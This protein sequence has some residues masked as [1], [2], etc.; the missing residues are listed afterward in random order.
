MNIRSSFFILNFSFFILACCCHAADVEISVVPSNK[1]YRY[2]IDEPI[3]V[4]LSIRNRTGKTIDTE[5]DGRFTCEVKRMGSPL[6]LTPY[7]DATLPELSIK[8]G[9]TEVVEID[10]TDLY[11]LRDEGD[12]FIRFSAANAIA[13][14]RSDGTMVN[15]NAGIPVKHVSQL[16]DD[17]TRREFHLVYLE[18]DQTEILFLRIIDPAG[19][20][21]WDT[22][23]LNRIWRIDEPKMGI[24]DSGLVTIMHRASQDLYII[25]ELL[26]ER[27][28][29]RM[30]SMTPLLTPEAQARVNMQPFQNMLLDPPKPKPKPW[31]KLW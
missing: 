27:N 23:W 19:E 18:R 9:E 3:Y 22:L 10:I 15:I 25:T 24:E 20:N 8:P 4:T 16:F 11:E 30:L 13:S 29:V 12:Y 7:A 6:S 26:S 28:E 31:W 21:A 14:G 5:K 1:S 2:V 17:G